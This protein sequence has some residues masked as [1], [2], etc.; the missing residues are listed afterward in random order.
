MYKHVAL[1]GGIG[2]FVIAAS[3]L[4]WVTS[5][6]NEI[7]DLCVKTLKQSFG[8]DKV[9]PGDIS[10]ITPVANDS[11]LCGVDVLSAGFPCQSFSKA[12]SNKGF[13]DPRG[14]VFFEIPKFINRLEEKPKVIVLENVEYLK[15]FDN[16]SRLTHVIHVLRRLG[17]W[18][19]I[20]TCQ[21]LNTLG[22][23]KI[24]QRRERLFIVAANRDWFRKN[25]VDFSAEELMEPCD[26]SDFLDTQS[27]APED[28]YM[29]DTNKYGRMLRRERSTHGGER[30]YQIR[31]STARACTLGVCPTL[32]ANMGRGG[33]NVPFLVDNWGIRRLTVEECLRLQ[34]FDSGDIVFPEE[35]FQKDQYEMIGNAVTVDLAARVLGSIEES[36]LIPLY[37]GKMEK[38]H[39]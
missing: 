24:P 33:H 38:S 25:S 13:N 1:F 4:G 12:G 36:L 27:K 21:V 37:L 5:Y 29:S 20:K 22:H 16:G 15:S 8:L 31:R 14:Q 34:G 2:G 19:N 6:I 26:L 23:T 35:S 11:R 30:L 28:H 32:T 39:L 3:R 9:I 7:D 17:Y 18:I 10:N